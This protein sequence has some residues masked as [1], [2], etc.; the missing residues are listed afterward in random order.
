VIRTRTGRLYER[1][2]TKSSHTSRLPEEA[3][4]HGYEP[5]FRFLRLAPLDL[6][7]DRLQAGQVVH[8][9]HQEPSDLLHDRVLARPHSSHHLRGG[10][11][12]QGGRGLS[13]GAPAQSSQAVPHLADK[14]A[15]ISREHHCLYSAAVSYRRETGERLA[16][17]SLWSSIRTETAG[18][19]IH[20]LQIWMANPNDTFA[21]H[22]GS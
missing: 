1:S 8:V 4:P 7:Q 22:D 6:C 12:P 3:C 10:Q 21:V 14:N 18:I 15:G 5:L 16:T 11:Q 9:E 19:L 13:G 2:Y 20:G 17:A